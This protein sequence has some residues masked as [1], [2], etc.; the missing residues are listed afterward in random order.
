MRN[1]KKKLSVLLMLVM[2]LTLVSPAASVNAKAKIKISKTKT[3]LSVGDT[4]TLKMTGTKKTVKWTT[5]NKKVATVS[6]KGKVV[7]KK[8]GSTKIKAKVSGKTYTCKV[9]VKKKGTVKISETTATMNQGDTKVLKITGTSSKVTWSS[10]S[11][12]VATVNAKGVIVAVAGGTTVIAASVNGQSYYCTIV[13]IAK[14][15]IPTD[16]ELTANISYTTMNTPYQLIGY[17]TN[18]NNYD[19]YIDSTAIFYDAAGTVLSTDDAYLVCLKA[20]GTAIVRYSHPEN[21]NYDD[22][23]YA[24]VAIT[25]AAKY[26]DYKLSYTD[27]VTFTASKGVKS[28]IVQATN[29]TAIKLNEIEIAA[30]FYKNGVLVGVSTDYEF[31]VQAG[32]T[33]VFE[34]SFPKD[35]DY[36]T[37]EFDNYVITVNEGYAY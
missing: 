37:L 35:S 15:L 22:I 23:P 18:N 10:S 29:T 28:M 12:Y 9:T 30:Q 36:K 7:A 33:A 6:K 13:V 25:N 19:V 17:I 5:S 26:S 14:S 31:D 11:P 4:I 2:L 20:K 27:K 3:T 21:A 34:L 8:V 16:A 32:I 24:N 1:L